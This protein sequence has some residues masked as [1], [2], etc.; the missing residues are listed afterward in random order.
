MPQS[1]AVNSAAVTLHDL[2]F[3]WPRASEPVLAIESFTIERGQRVFLCGPSGSGKSTLLGV[4]GGV[5]QPGGGEVGVL[6]TDLGRLSPAARDRF[7]ADHIGLVFQQFNLL[8]YLGVVDNVLL[9]TRFSARR[10]AAVGDDAARAARELLAVLGLDDTRLLHAP[11]TELSVGQQQRVAVARALLG[12]PGLV[13]ADE[14]TSALDSDSR[15]AFM[16]LLFRECARTGATLLFVSHDR[17]LA[18]GF[19]RVVELPAL[20]RASVAA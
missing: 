5:L 8:P 14:P 6:G 12:A 16:K 7:R 17:A 2:G 9:A 10:A 4:I 1:D 18:D 15:A 20:N 13:I 19:D 11:V 3:A